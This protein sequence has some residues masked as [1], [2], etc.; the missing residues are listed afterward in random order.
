MDTAKTAVGHD[1][2]DVAFLMFAD[3]RGDD[4]V[5]LR[6]VARLLSRRTQVGDQ[7]IGVQTLCVGNGRAEDGRENDLV[8]RAER[9]SEGV[10]E[11]AAA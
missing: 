7:P 11:D 5:V 4:V 1:H 8:S 10:V 6:D 2:D 3:D 9:C